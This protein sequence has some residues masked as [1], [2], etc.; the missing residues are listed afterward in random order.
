MVTV[1]PVECVVESRLAAGEILCPCGGVLAAWGWARLRRLVGVAAPIRPRR[2]RCRSCRV[3]HVLLP[4]TM[5]SRRAYLASTIWAALAAKASG[6]GHRPTAA[7]MGIPASTVRGWLRRMGARVESTR[8]WF[9]ALTVRAG[10]DPVVPKASGSA[11]T[12]MTLAVDAAVG[13]LAQRFGRSSV[14]GEVTAPLVAVT[15]S[16]GLLLAPDWPSTGTTGAATRV[17]PARSGW[18]L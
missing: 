3:T 4:A 7:E 18:F 17:D 6:R 11:W 15:A 8:H 16:A 5:L 10:I 2:G 9:I 14:I 13:A 12:D 1:S